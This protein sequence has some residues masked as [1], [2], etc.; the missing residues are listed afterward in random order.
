M[1]GLLKDIHRH[2]KEDLQ[3]LLYRNIFWACSSVWESIRFAFERSRVRS[4]SSPPDI[5]TPFVL[6][7]VFHVYI[8]RTELCV[9]ICYIYSDLLVR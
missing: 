2:D 7:R 3:T 6:Q 5:E 4:P 1:D 8:H 9:I